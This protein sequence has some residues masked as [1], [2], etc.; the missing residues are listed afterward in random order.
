ME[1]YIFTCYNLTG[2]V[3]LGNTCFEEVSSLINYKILVRYPLGFLYA[4]S[5]V[6]LLKHPLE[7][8]LG[9]LYH[10]GNVSYFEGG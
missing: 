4:W 2:D 6:K 7:H 1:N 10:V 9:K 5:Y 3:N 8:N